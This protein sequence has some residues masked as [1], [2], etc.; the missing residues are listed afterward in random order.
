VSVAFYMDHHVYS[1]ITDTLREHGY[2]VVTAEQDGHSDEN[3]QALLDRAT[4]LGRV[5]VTYDTDLLVEGAARQRR[6]QQF[7]GIVYAHQLRLTIGQIIYDL[8]IIGSAGTADDCA[9]MIYQ[10]P[11]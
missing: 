6:G 9:N 4:A 10:L 5:L 11:L 1:V 2:E 3:D 8:E 7:T